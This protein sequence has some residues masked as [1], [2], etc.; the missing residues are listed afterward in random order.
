[1][2]CGVGHPDFDYLKEAEGSHATVHQDYRS[3]PPAGIARML[4]AQKYDSSLSTYLSAKSAN[5]TG[6]SRPI[7]ITA[8]WDAVEKGD[9]TFSTGCTPT[10]FPLQ[11]SVGQATVSTKAMNGGSYQGYNCLTTKAAWET[12]RMVVTPDRLAVMKKR[13][14][15]AIEFWAKT[16]RV[17]PVENGITITQNSCILPGDVIGKTVEGAD[18]VMV[19]TARPSP[20]SAVMGYAQ[21]VQWDQW[22]RCTVGLFNWVPEYIDVP[23]T[24][25]DGTREVEMHTAL[26]EIVHLLGGI[27]PGATKAATSF[28]DS[29]GQ[30]LQPASMFTVEPDPA[31]P[32]SGKFRTLITTPK[33]KALTQKYFACPAA[34]GLPLEDLPLGKGAHWEARVMG[35]ELMS[36][37]TN[38]GQT[39]ISDLTLAFL[40]DTNMY[41]V[42]YSMAGSIVSPSTDDVSIAGTPTQMIDVSDSA[43]YKPPEVLP[44]GAIRWGY[45]EGCKFLNS[46]P[47]TGIL[48]PYTCD[49]AQD[50]LC[51]A[52]N[53]MSAVCS[54]RTDWSVSTS[55]FV[56][57]GGYSQSGWGGSSLAG[58]QP[59]PAVKQADTNIPP[60]FRWFATAADAAKASLITTASEKTTG[61]FNDA[62]DY[63]PV[64]V[65]YWNCMFAVATVNKTAG[66]ESTNV[67][68]ES[69]SN[70]FTAAAND[71]TQFG[72]QFRCPSCRCF[73]SSLSALSGFNVNPAFPSYGLCYRS[74]CARYDY[75]QVG[76][77]GQLDGKAYWYK[78]PANGGKL[79]IPGWSGALTCPNAISFC[80]KETITNQVYAEQ[81]VLYELIFWGTILGTLVICFLVCICP[82]VRRKCINCSKRLCGARSFEPPGGHEETVEEEEENAGEKLPPLSS[83]V[84][85]STN[86]I[87]FAAGTA[88]VG[89]ISYLLKTA[90]IL[91]ISL[92]ILGMGICVMLLSFAGIMASHAKSLNGPSCWIIVYFFVN[93]VV[94]LLLVF[95][96]IYTST[97]SNWGLYVDKYLDTFL[98]SE[99]FRKFINTVNTTRAE[100]VAQATTVMKASSSYMLA[101][102]AVT[103]CLFVF[104]LIFSARIL[105]MRVL[106][107][108]LFT[109]INNI[110]IA[111][112]A[113][114][115]G[116]GIYIGVKGSASLGGLT[117][118][119][120]LLVALGVL[121]I[122]IS[123]IGHYG[124]SQKNFIVIMVFMVLSLGL[125]AAGSAAAYVCFN[126]SDLVIDYIDAMNDD[127]IGRIASSLNLSMGK[128]DIMV[129]VQTNLRTIGLGF[130]VVSILQIIVFLAAGFFMLAV[131]QWR[132]EN[133]V[134]YCAS[135]WRGAHYDGINLTCSPIIPFPSHVFPVADARP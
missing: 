112:G 61:G 33:V 84:L 42:D 19:M 38:T 20:F 18:L 111:F 68:M 43:A 63:M 59:Y 69:L 39:Y 96:A 87:T 12:T 35:P 81:N 75:L 56:S 10:A 53:K 108:I 78:C 99:Y 65:G 131:K 41:V 80:S 107:S 110:F 103:I 129:Y 28:V 62:M 125:L 91:M 1:M 72:G 67:D 128:L 120:G 95:F 85:F 36:Y 22:Q 55:D 109:F 2:R 21:C 88:I 135:C 32:N 74:N 46:P 14:A 45:G 73:K 113:L 89:Y 98:Q 31:Y 115:M 8:V 48:A 116:V 26:H 3:E 60:F 106:I 90:K 101:V 50:Y 13:T 16:L 70:S 34:A 126:K 130:A 97:L 133:G 93:L 7:R 47:S 23:N 40:E 104:S 29:A 15:D 49:V 76:L 77:K 118:I 9:N 44:P 79:Y 54:I 66:G 27:F 30:P 92:N 119:L 83:W 117:Q 51:T 100:Q 127:T 64:P 134:R 86:L 57:Y 123:A 114:F 11:C 122:V 24:A 121:F 6:K 37:G 52:D 17:T 58:P 71:M 82:S 102:S 25:L 5:S 4:P 94:T 132:E 124:H 105:S